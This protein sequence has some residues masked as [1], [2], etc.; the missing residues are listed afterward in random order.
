[1]IQL[2]SYL[3]WID[4]AIIVGYV[5]MLLG[6]GY[7]LMR[8]APSFEEFLI[9]GRTMTTPVL[10]CTLASTYYGLD[11]LFGNVVGAVVEDQRRAARVRVVRGERAQVVGDRGLLDLGLGRDRDRGSSRSDDEEP[12]VAD[13]DV[14]SLEGVRGYDQ[15]VCHE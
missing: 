2:H 14:R 10:V 9:A 15:R 8:R 6:I 3:S 4:L 12:H 11:V 13:E 7:H 5:L 1:M